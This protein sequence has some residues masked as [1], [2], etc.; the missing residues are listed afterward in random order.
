MEALLRR[1]GP[2][3]AARLDSG[4]VAALFG[5]VTRQN[6]LFG[7]A[8]TGEPRQLESVS[9]VRDRPG[10]SSDQLAPNDAR[11]VLNRKPLM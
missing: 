8:P 5:P 1:A 4:Q 11:R 2:P 3:T 9:P 7:A 6:P 10:L